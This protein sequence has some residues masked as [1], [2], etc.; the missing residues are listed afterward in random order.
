LQSSP[1]RLAAKIKGLRKEDWSDFRVCSE[2]WTVLDTEQ[3]SR[4][5]LEDR[6]MS[7]A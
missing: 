6:Y 7:V 2:P 4:D 5:D 3:S 1:A